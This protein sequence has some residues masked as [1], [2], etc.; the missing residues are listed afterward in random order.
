MDTR[1][2]QKGPNSLTI[3]NQK[4]GEAIGAHTS[5]TVLHCSTSNPDASQ[6]LFYSLVVDTLHMWLCLMENS[7]KYSWPHFMNKLSSL[8][9]SADLISAPH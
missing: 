6:V 7:K 8:S 4:N 9:G 3:N 5:S 1:E 2:V